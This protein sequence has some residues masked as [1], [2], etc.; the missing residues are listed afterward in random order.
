MKGNLQ[1]DKDGK[2]NMSFFKLPVLDIDKLRYELFEK[3]KHNE[4]IDPVKFE[5]VSNNENS[6]EI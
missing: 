1:T 4:T 5:L 6:S 3:A 2:L